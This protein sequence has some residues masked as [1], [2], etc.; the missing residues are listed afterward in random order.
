[1]RF[2]LPIS[3]RLPL[4]LCIAAAAALAAPAA[5]G[6][7]TLN[8]TTTADER[9]LVAN[10]TCSLREAV[11]ATNADADF[12]GCTGSGYGDD[13]I[14]LPGG[15]YAL[16]LAG[17]MDDGNVTGDIDVNELTDQALSIQRAGAAPVTIDGG[18]AG[19]RVME[20]RNGG[21]LNVDGLTLRNGVPPGAVIAGGIVALLG[22]DL[23]L[24][25]STLSNNTA[26]SGGAVGIGDSDT[27]LTNVTLSGNSATVDGG[28]LYANSATANVVLRSVTVT[29]NT[30][31]SDNTGGTGNGGGIFASNGTWSIQNTIVAGN[32]DLSGGAPDCQEQAPGTLASLGSV[33]IG[34]AT[35]CAGLAPGAGDILNQAA[36]LSP[37]ADNAGPTFTHALSA[38][39][40]ALNAASAAAPAT[41]QRGLARA[42]A[43]DIG[44]Y[45]RVL[46]GGVA[47]NKV[48]TAGSDKI[49]GTAGADGILGLG[50]KDTLSG[51]AGNDGLCGGAGKDGLFGGAGKDRLLG[52]AGKDKLVGGKG[53]D[54]LKG[55]PGKDKQR[56]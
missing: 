23:N 53:K 7:A 30:A 42:G 6:A 1:M 33:L 20:V 35:G 15:V 12:G 28:A 45:E 21:T 43:P 9:D 16:T 48:G 4:L 38:T 31:D 8:V 40:P 51:L 47:V 3:A 37:L 22:S 54:V 32:S 5:A 14:L 36:G 25:N 13:T 2:R 11:Q 24:S 41:D 26:N 27:T 49:K 34:D 52:Q 18:A 10:G 44:S 56:Q 19:D 29:N 55:G 17:A 50:G 46:C 39:S